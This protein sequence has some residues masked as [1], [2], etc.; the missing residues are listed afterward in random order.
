MSDLVARLNAVAA[1]ADFEDNANVIREGA[2]EIARLLAAGDDLESKL[3]DVAL[4]RD[5]LR[6]TPEERAA[7]TWFSRFGRPQNGPVIGKHAAALR[8][9]LERMK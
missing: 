4:Q 3:V 1:L 6:L 7:V 8:G 5:R 9:L 2:T